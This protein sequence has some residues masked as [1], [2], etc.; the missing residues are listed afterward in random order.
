MGVRE[1]A[2]ALAEIGLGEVYLLSR[3]E[4]RSSEREK[5]EPRAEDK[6]TLLRKHFNSFRDCTRCPLHRSR[7]QV[8]FGDGNP[9]SPVVFVGEAPGEEEDAQGRPF[10][11]RAGRYLNQK[12]QEVLGL[13]REEVYITNVCK[14]RPPENRKP[15]SQEIRACFPYLRREL[16]IIRPKVICC[17]GA[18]AGEGILGKTMPITKLRGKV[19]PYPYNPKI[20][21]F[22]TYHPAYILR[23]PKAEG[24]F[25]EDLKN[26]RGSIA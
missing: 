11:G 10:V 7:S 1:T 9:D 2:R 6:D 14:C 5:S 21:V 15:T 22:L 12:I 8:V 20:K 13:R 4:K 19:F 18:T 17:L 16:E 3:T 25:L 24:E 23:N 26:S